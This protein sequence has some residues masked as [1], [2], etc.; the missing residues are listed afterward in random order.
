MEHAKPSRRMLM[1]K[2]TTHRQVA[3]NYRNIGK[4]SK[5][6]FKVAKEIRRLE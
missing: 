6:R 4:F 2:L 3:M 5:I 1:N